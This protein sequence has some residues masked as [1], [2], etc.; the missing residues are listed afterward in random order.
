[1]FY[2]LTAAPRALRNFNLLARSLILL[3]AFR[4]IIVASATW[5]PA[6]DELNFLHRAVCVNQTLLAGDWPGLHECMLMLFKSP[7]L[8]LVLLPLGQVGDHADLIRM[9]PVML[10]LFNFSVVLGIAALSS[11]LRVPISMLLVTAVAIAANPLNYAVGGALLID[12]FLGFLVTLLVLFFAFEIHSR[13]TCTRSFVIRGAFWGLIG[14]LGVMSKITFGYFV[15][16]LFIPMIA[17]VWRREG[18]RAV[19]LRCISCTIVSMPGMIVFVFYA[20]QY[21]AHA[22]R[23]SFGSLAQLYGD[24][25]GLVEFVTTQL[26]ATKVGGVVLLIMA[27]VAIAALVRRRQ[28]DRTALYLFLVVLGYFWLTANG[29]N[30]DARFFLPF[31]LTVPWC[32]AIIMRRPEGIEVQDGVIRDLALAGLASV[33]FALPA[34]K[35]YDLSTLEISRETLRLAPK[36]RPIRVLTASDT[37]DFNVESVLLAYQLDKTH[38]PAGLLVDTLVYDTVSGRTLDQSIARLRLADIVLFRFPLDIASSSLWSNAHQEDYLRVAQ[39]EGLELAVL[40]PAPSVHV[41]LMQ[42]P[43]R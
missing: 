17:L 16:T 12:T 40:G 3:F 28:I 39:A 42:H 15:I 32:I 14:T 31:W 43:P 24:N 27:V 9:A 4:S 26:M 6:W 2:G 38:F 5:R 11:R 13:A 22:L 25:L 37:G 36:D 21:F 30:R 41:F 20:N 23:A 18:A 1:M 35:N 7:V 34:I 33:F 29:V 10:A 8:M 19:L